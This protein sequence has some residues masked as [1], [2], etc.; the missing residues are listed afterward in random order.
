MPVRNKSFLN[1]EQ[2]LN[3]GVQMQK[4]HQHAL[5][6]H[7]RQIPNLLPAHQLDRLYQGIVWL[8]RDRGLYRMHERVIHKKRPRRA[9][10]P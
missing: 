7:H 10:A 5:L 4:T 1:P 9:F 8:N 3:G 6:V 2:C